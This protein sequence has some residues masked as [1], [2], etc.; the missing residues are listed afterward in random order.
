L[1]ATLADLVANRPIERGDFATGTYLGTIEASETSATLRLRRRGS[2]SGHRIEVEKTFSLEAG[3]AELRVDYRID[4]LPE[5]V[6]FLWAVEI[7]VAAMPGGAPDRVYV[8]EHG[9]SLGT[10]DTRLELPKCG[11]IALSDSW[12]D[13]AVQLQWDKPARV[14][15]HPIETVSQS[16]GGFEAVHQSAAVVPHWKVAGD[17]SGTWSVALALRL[18]AA[19]PLQLA[20]RKRAASAAVAAP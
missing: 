15:A 8:D 19:P 17:E 7:N 18:A 9:R 1:D 3:G 12:R 10:L 13:L 14:W 6:A 20:Q 11:S 2:A 4:G 16:E 5:G